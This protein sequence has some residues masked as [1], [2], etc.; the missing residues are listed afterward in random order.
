MSRAR[1]DRHNGGVNDYRD[2][3]RAAEARIERATP[4][5]IPRDRRRDV[6]RPP[7]P[8][9]VVS[10]TRLLNRGPATARF[11]LN[12]ERDYQPLAHTRLAG[13]HLYIL[14]DPEVIIDVLLTRSRSTMKGR[15]LQAAKA[16]LGNGLLTSESDDHM[17]QRRLV[18]PA[19][20]RERIAG[21]SLDMVRRAAQ[22]SDMW[23]DGQQVE[24]VRDMSAL[25]LA[26]VGDTL[27]RADLSGEA[28]EVGEAL[29]GVLE[30]AGGRLLLGPAA[31]RV[32]TP[33]RRRA[34]Q[35]SARLEAVVARLIAEHRSSG[36]TG[37]ILSMLVAAQEDGT[38]MSDEQVRDEV[39][40]LM[41]AGH[42]T[43]A[44][45]LSWTWLLLS[46]NPSVAAWWR[47]ELDALFADR[48]P[49]MADIATM[50]RTQAIV[51]ESMRLFP[52]AW[53]MGRR[54][55]ADLEVGGYTL[56]SGAIVL[57]SMLAMH[58]SERWWGDPHQ[59]EPAR[60]IRADG[61]FDEA[62]PGQ[63]KGAWFGFG[64]GNR[65]CIGEQFA[66]TEAMLVMAT[67]GRHWT[68]ER[69]SASPV[70]LRPNI[71]LRPTG[72]TRMVLRRR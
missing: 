62:A 10:L 5:N 3:I 43:T 34:L 64:F 70:G 59:F 7:G 44:M 66:W 17:R 42:E 35:S 55:L 23:R 12:L 26:I 4:A 68:L 63:P 48:D 24:V 28:A 8:S 67:L 60:W 36:D 33:G 61:S 13:Q 58:R 65:R 1:N 19:F 47:Q 71:T 11:F 9:Q 39:M 37:D 49:T 38:G 41:L 54:L 69:T 29:S 27:F 31:M 18:Q 22:H 15:G 30:G 45:T 52:P 40:T 20:H 56:P 51:A 72:D 32:P 25:T 57:A 46:G 2:Q 53:V 16:L 6:S 50:P 21:Y 14:N